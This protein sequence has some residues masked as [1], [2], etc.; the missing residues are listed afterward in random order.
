MT[1]PLFF[2]L[3][4]LFSRPVWHA[5]SGN[6]YRAGVSARLRQSLKMVSFW[7]ELFHQRVGSPAKNP[8][9]AKSAKKERLRIG[10]VTRLKYPRPNVAISR[11]NHPG[12]P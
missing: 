8:K 1:H 3:S 11:I 4:F 2:L 9:P 12:S 6:S 7:E 5:V 10:D